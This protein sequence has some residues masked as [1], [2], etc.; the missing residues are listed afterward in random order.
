MGKLN[1]VKFSHPPVVDPHPGIVTVIVIVVLTLILAFL[2][3]QGNGRGFSSTSQLA[4]T[5]AL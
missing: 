5:T 4:R 3:V 1:L 2:Q